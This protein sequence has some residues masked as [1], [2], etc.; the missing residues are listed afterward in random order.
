MSSKEWGKKNTPEKPKK[1][2]KYFFDICPK[3]EIENQENLD[4]KN[5]K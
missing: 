4:Q 1:T 2:K 3:K 5:K